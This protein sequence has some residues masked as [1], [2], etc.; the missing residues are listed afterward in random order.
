MKHTSVVCCAGRFPTWPLNVSLIRQRMANK[1]VVKNRLFWLVECSR[2]WQ[3]LFI[4]SI[5]SFTRGKKTLRKPKFRRASG[6]RPYR[7]KRK[8]LPICRS[9][10]VWECV[11]G[12]LTELAV[13]TGDQSASSSLDLNTD[14][15]AELIRRVSLFWRCGSINNF[16]RRWLEKSV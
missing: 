11:I 5:L 7:F 2:I 14:I 15:I 10:K 3:E 4:K 9:K 6:F 12:P 16:R 8:W 13:Q 1:G